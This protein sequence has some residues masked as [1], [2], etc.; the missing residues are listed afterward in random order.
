MLPARYGI[1]LEIR[2]RT[3]NETIKHP[4]S[5]PF[6]E[7]SV[8]RAV[9]RGL[10]GKVSK[11]K[12]SQ[13]LNGNANFSKSGKKKS[14]TKWELFWAGRRAP[15]LE[16]NA[17]HPVHGW[18]KPNARGIHGLGGEHLKKD[19]TYSRETRG[20]LEIEGTFSDFISITDKKDLLMSYFGVMSPST[21]FVNTVLEILTT[22]IK[23]E[24]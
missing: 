7:P 4:S 24:K 12:T 11:D 1:G 20:K 2:G 17:I 10:K 6:S 8:Q 19:T 13:G 21:T 9:S 22:V 15:C 18:T 14:D 23:Q 5:L 3:P 16:A